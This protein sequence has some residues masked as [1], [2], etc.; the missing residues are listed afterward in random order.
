MFYGFGSSICGYRSSKT[1]IVVRNLSMNILSKNSWWCKGH[2]YS[3]MIELAL[4]EII[5]HLWATCKNK[6]KKIRVSQESVVSLLD[7]TTM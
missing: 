6:D 3:I 1:G 5:F 2:V 4:V 7:N